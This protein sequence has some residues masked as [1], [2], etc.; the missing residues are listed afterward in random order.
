MAAPALRAG[1]AQSAARICSGNG[2]P[3]TAQ[4]ARC[5]S[6]AGTQPS[7]LPLTIVEA[8]ISPRKVSG[9]GEAIGRRLTRATSISVLIAGSAAPKRQW[10]RSGA[11]A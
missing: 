7:S 9:T 5:P 10:M 4:P 8:I 6:V 3:S 1:K 11:P 2:T